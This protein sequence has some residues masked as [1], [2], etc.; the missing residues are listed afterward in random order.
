[1]RVVRK[2]QHGAVKPGKDVGA[3]GFVLK[4]ANIVIR[5]FASASTE[6][7]LHRHPF[8]CPRP[9]PGFCLLS[10]A[11][12][13]PACAPSPAWSQAAANTAGSHP[14]RP[15]DLTVAERLRRIVQNGHQGAGGRHRDLAAAAG[16]A[17]FITA[18][19]AHRSMRAASAPS[20]PSLS[21]GRFREM[22]RFLL[23][24]GLQPPG[25]F[26]AH[27]TR[28]PRGDSAGLISSRGR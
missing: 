28:R 23:S 12:R 10:R 6:N 20:N 8:S 27:R 17:A 22:L 24:L 25:F 19:I 4:T 5:F 11:A 21:A 7:G 16:A 18:D 2:I 3:E 26:F 13:Q 1:M 9:G 15:R 14:N